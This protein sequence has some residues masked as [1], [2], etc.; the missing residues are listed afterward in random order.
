MVSQRLDPRKYCHPQGRTTRGRLC[1]SI[2]LAVPTIQP[3]QKKTES[4]IPS[5]SFTPSFARRHVLNID[6]QEVHSDSYQVV[7]E[8]V[9]CHH[10]ERRPNRQAVAVEVAAAGLC[11]QN[12]CAVH[13]AVN[14]SLVA[15]VVVAALVHDTVVLAFARMAQ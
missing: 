2:R 14:K 13:T 12:T 1:V 5:I 8:A 15:V 9:G 4:I 10:G 6:R 7:E 3:H 11:L